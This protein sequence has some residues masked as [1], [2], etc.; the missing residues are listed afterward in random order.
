ML[1]FVRLF[2]KLM[3]YLKLLKTHVREPDGPAREPLETPNIPLPDNHVL[4]E[5]PHL[6]ARAE[7]L[8][9]L[10]GPLTVDSG[11]H[12][13]EVGVTDPHALVALYHQ[14]PWGVIG[15]GNRIA[16]MQWGEVPE[17]GWEA[18]SP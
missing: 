14:R 4:P 16:L 17:N 18:W 11:P 13:C 2:R 1:R 7:L 6:V 15:T 9:T 10:Y 12:G 3:S 8:I 5:R